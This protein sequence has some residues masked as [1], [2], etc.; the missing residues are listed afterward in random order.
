MALLCVTRHVTSGESA[1][2]LRC[3]LPYYAVRDIRHGVRCPGNDVNRF[4]CVPGQILLSRFS[5]SPLFEQPGQKHPRK[6]ANSALPHNIRHHTSA[7]F[8][9]SGFAYIE[10]SRDGLSRFPKRG[11]NHE[12]GQRNLARFARQSVAVTTGHR[13]RIDKMLQCLTGMRPYRDS[14]VSLEV[15]ESSSTPQTGSMEESCNAPNHR[16]PCLVWRITASSGVDVAG[17]QRNLRCMMRPKTKKPGGGGRRVRE[18]REEGF[19]YGV[20]KNLATGMNFIP[21]TSSI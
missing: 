15:E 3:V 13:L 10:R 5:I 20:R 12:P 18:K 7:E 21:L 8:R 2:H 6:I 11:Q 9:A 17:Q 16:A 19:S 4:M 1:H 14:N